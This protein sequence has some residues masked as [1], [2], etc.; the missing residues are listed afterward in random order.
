MAF[1]NAHLLRMGRVEGHWHAN[2]TC[3]EGKVSA[4]APTPATGRSCPHHRS[5]IPMWIRNLMRPRNPVVM[6]SPMGLGS[7]C[8]EGPHRGSTP[9]EG[10]V[11]LGLPAR[12]T[13][14]GPDLEGVQVTDTSLR[15][16]T[17][18]PNIDGGVSDEDQHCQRCQRHL[19]PQTMQGI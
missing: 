8:G 9:L 18:R 10:S 5:K 2:T 16:V 12:T 3:Q 13:R 4:S 1:G 17:G 15:M 19:T 11:A 14:S 6:P 7:Q